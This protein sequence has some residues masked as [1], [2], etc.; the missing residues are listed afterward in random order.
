MVTKTKELINVGCE[1]IYEA[2]F[3]KNGIFTMADILVKKADD[4]DIYEVKAR[5]SSK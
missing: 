3:K 5:I 4:W 2:T 1:V